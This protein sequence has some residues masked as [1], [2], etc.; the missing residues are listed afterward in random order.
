MT[1]ISESDLFPSMRD[2]SGRTMWEITS[3]YSFVYRLIAVDVRI[4]VLLPSWNYKMLISCEFSVGSYYFLFNL[5]VKWLRGAPPP[6]SFTSLLLEQLL[7]GLTHIYTPHACV[8]CL[9]IMQR[10]LIKE[11]KY[12]VIRTPLYCKKVFYEHEQL[13][14]K[15]NDEW[16]WQD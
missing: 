1:H 8:Y 11:S 13:P 7:S 10:C 6:L 9:T 4:L 5:H 3:N 15:K 2:T 16:S 12:T 14:T